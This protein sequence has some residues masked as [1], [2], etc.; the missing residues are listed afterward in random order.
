MSNK[1]QTGLGLTDASVTFSASATWTQVAKEDA[2]RGALL[3]MNVGGSNMG[4]FFAPLGGIGGVPNT[5]PSISAT[6]G[7]SG[8]YTLVSNGSYEPDGGF[9]PNNEVWAFGTSTQVLT[10]SISQKP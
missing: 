7:T 4:V 1:S 9:V 2:E 5:A 8:V 6:T 10:A 3:L